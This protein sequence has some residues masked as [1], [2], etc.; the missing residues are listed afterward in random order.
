MG[1]KGYDFKTY[2]L[3]S[4]LG[5]I[6]LMIPFTVM[7]ETAAD[8]RSPVFLSATAVELLI[9]LAA[10]CCYRKLRKKNE[11]QA[12]TEQETAQIKD[13]RTDEINT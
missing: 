12:E 9:V 7:G 8:F 2:L 4:E 11:Q 10:F 13:A 1:A 6:P 3:G 5:L